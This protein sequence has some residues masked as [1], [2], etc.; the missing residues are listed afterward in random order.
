MS[1][2]SSLNQK[3]NANFCEKKTKSFYKVKLKFVWFPN[4]L[5]R[6][7]LFGSRK[8]SNLF[9][10]RWR[11]AQRFRRL[12]RFCRSFRK[13][14]IFFCS[15]KNSYY[16]MSYEL[17]R[18]QESIESKELS[19]ISVKNANFSTAQMNRDWIQTITG[20]KLHQEAHHFEREDA[21]ANSTGKRGDRQGNKR[22]IGKN[23]TKFRIQTQNRKVDERN[24]IQHFASGNWQSLDF[25]DKLEAQIEQLRNWIRSDLQWIF[26]LTKSLQNIIQYSSFGS[27]FRDSFCF[28][29]HFSPSTCDWKAVKM[30]F[31]VNQVLFELK[32]IGKKYA[33]ISMTNKIVVAKVS[34]IEPI[35]CQLHHLPGR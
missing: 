3:S 30:T 18:A 17:P 14:T 31:S 28:F 22:G 6:K 34:V 13:K 24:K 33:K 9:C 11:N 4:K 15:L 32:K 1:N 35:N 21:I 16:P 19:I 25:S 26:V 12:C 27:Q 8:Q 7:R 20:W 2:F 29:P 23:L 5:C 10:W